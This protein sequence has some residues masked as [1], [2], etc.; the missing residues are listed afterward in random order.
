MGT[1]TPCA[2]VDGVPQS[3]LPIPV[4]TEVERG[5]PPFEAVPYNF[6]SHTYCD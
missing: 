3:I 4:L 1:R 5:N 6:P 2:L